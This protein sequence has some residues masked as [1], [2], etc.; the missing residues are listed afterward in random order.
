MPK[1]L[2]DNDRMR[3]VYLNIINN[4]KYAMSGGGKL[5]VRTQVLKGKN[6]SQV[7][8]ES[9]SSN[10]EKDRFLRICFTDTG[11]GIKPEH[12]GKIFD[13]F[14]TTKPEDK[15]TGLGLS[16]CYSIIEKHG[17][18]LEAE[19]DGKNGTTFLIDLPLNQNQNNESPFLDETSE[20]IA[21]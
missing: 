5:T 7:E 13:P 15:G 2:V 11:P 4:A 20:T 16:V 19:S 12:L 14:F 8:P 3:Q 1:L 18:V 21:S 9:S 17:G 6:S 10:P